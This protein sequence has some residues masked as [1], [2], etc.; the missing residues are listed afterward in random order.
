MMS[1]VE[2]K[3]TFSRSGF[4]LQ[5]ASFVFSLAKEA[6]DVKSQPLKALMKRKCF[7]I[8]EDFEEAMLNG[9]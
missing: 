8:N 1:M 5:W 3:K 6:E 4:F 9:I 2:K 7:G